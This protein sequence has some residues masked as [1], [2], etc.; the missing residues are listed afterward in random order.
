MMGC[1]ERKTHQIMTAATAS[2]RTF[3]M[4]SGAFKRMRLHWVAVVAEESDSNLSVMQP[5]TRSLSEAK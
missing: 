4:L 1:A 3:P 2:G 5:A